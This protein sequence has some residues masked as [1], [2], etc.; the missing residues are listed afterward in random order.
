MSLLIVLMNTYRLSHRF[1]HFDDAS[2]HRVGEVGHMKGRKF[3]MILLL[4][5]F[6]AAPS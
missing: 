2:I 6:A 4:N 5:V 3:Q 1:P